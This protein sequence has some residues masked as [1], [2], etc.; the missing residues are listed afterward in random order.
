MKL[1]T[2]R[3]GEIDIEQEEIINF[4]Q[5]LYGFRE[6][7]EFI[8]LEDAETDFFW[9]QSVVNPDLAFLVSQPWIFCQDYEFDLGEKTKKELKLESPEDVLVIN[10][11][12]VPDDPQ[13]MTMNLKAP[14]VINEQER[15]GKQIILND[16]DYPIKYRLFGDEESGVRNQESGTRNRKTG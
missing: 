15:L 12:T 9:L 16:T 13:Q 2:T 6:Q 5:G 7:Q 3:F 1:E 4:A 14:L 8:L 11:I 10:T